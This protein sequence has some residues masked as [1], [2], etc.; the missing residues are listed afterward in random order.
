M[1]PTAVKVVLPTILLGGWVLFAPAVYAAGKSAEAILKE[2]DAVKLPV[3]DADKKDDRSAV[4]LHQINQREA[5]EKRARL[6]LQLYKAAPD[7]KRVPALLQ[8]R[9][10][11]IGMHLEGGRY[12]ELLRELEQVAARASDKK[13]K[14]EASYIRAQLKLNPISSKG[15][16]D[17]SGV[18]DFLKIAASD[19]RAVDLL[20]TAAAATSDEKKKNT[21]LDRLRTQFP[22]SDYV[23]MLQGSHDKGESLGKPFH[24]IFTD[25]IGGSSVS[26]HGL[27]GKVVVVDFWA[28]WC[29]P[30]V[31]EMPKMKELYSKYRDQGVEFIGVSLDESK[32]EGGLD[33]LKA[34][35]KENGIKWPQFY[36]GK[37]WHG[38]FSSSWGINSIPCV[39]VVDADGKL[40]STDARGKLEKMIPELL[41]QKRPTSTASAGAGGG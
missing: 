40:H 35:V 25:A 31:G 36:Q 26:M 22:D 29:G 34:F 12:N 18:E 6:I 23:G 32:E 11:T 13:L 20:G 1:R 19:P 7:H 39:F 4:R 24:L 33:K 14:I 2:I 8:E 10:K 3:L 15:S 5:S 28:T 21:L 27:K 38:D 37:G 16:P 30:C 41:K 9:W 17:A